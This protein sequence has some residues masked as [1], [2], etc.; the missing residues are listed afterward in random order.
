MTCWD[1]LQIEPTL[2]QKLIKC[3][4]AK[5]LQAYH[6]EEDP[7]GFQKLRVAFEEALEKS[8]YLDSQSCPNKVMPH[9][10][11]TSAKKKSGG[12]EQQEHASWRLLENNAD[13]ASEGS[14]WVDEP[15]VLAQQRMARIADLYADFSRRV[16]RVQWQEIFADLR[17]WPVD[18]RLLLSFSLFAFLGQNPWVPPFVW[19]L[20]QELFDWRAVQIDLNKRF[21]ETMVDAVFWRIDNCRWM[22]GY[23]SVPIIPLVDYDTY[24]YHREHA[25][26]A[27]I[28]ADLE[29]AE[30][31]L[32]RA[33]SLLPGDCQLQ[34]LAIHSRLMAG[35]N[36]SALARSE[37]LTRDH[38]DDL[39][40]RLQH[41][42]LLLANGRASAALG[43]FQAMLGNAP[44][45]TA[46]LIGL[47]RSHMALGNLFEAQRL[48]EAALD[49]CPDHV[50]A[51]MELLRVCHRLTSRSLA[52]LGNQ[53][54]SAN[55]LLRIAEAYFGSGMYPQAEKIIADHIHQVVESDVY[56][57]WARI[58]DRLE[59]PQK[60]VALFDQ[61]RQIAEQNGENQYNILI[62]R[63]IFHYNRDAFQLAIADLERAR[64]MSLPVIDT[65]VWYY[66]ADAYYQT[67][68]FDQSIQHF[69]VL[70]D[71]DDSEPSCYLYR[72]CAHFGKQD[73]ASA[74]KDFQEALQ[75]E[76]YCSARLWIGKCHVEMKQYDQALAAFDDAEAFEPDSGELFHYRAR[77]AFERGDARGARPH[78]DRS[79]ALDPENL[80][81]QRLAG[82]I[83]DALGDESRA[84]ACFKMYLKQPQAGPM[85]GV[86]AAHYCLARNKIG[87][88][89]KYLEPMLETE[90]KSWTL[91][92][93]ADVLSKQGKWKRALGYTEKYFETVERSA[94]EIDEIA[95]FL[96][97]KL[98][99]IFYWNRPRE[100]L[101]DLHQACELEAC[102]MA[103]YYLSLAYFDLRDLPNCETFARAAL[104]RDPSNPDFGKLVEGIERFK[105]FGWLRQKLIS[106]KAIKLWEQT[107][108]EPWYCVGD[109]GDLGF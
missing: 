9:G 81:S 21:P 7:V 60:A 79:L 42:C 106:E 97:G 49:R 15:E 18:A 50:E 100:S 8:K 68:A 30:S 88:A 89:V 36:P 5:L 83:Y 64:E 37:T 69:N 25:A 67:N 20:A 39:D 90:E 53:S 70:I 80:S 2:N 59:Q 93:L 56:L 41:A 102:D 109:F 58:W 105:R 38:P 98:K 62:H 27:I 3:A 11:E 44:D 72:G 32:A 26:H 104:S 63:G 84:M 19:A 65:R 47:A 101:P 29:K 77:C 76:Y 103:F 99:Y 40:G 35:D 95:F 14:R 71:A 52:E 1:I 54:P 34:R 94:E 13:A 45:N 33:S 24:L 87:E 86:W 57:L 43:A 31:H 6:P 61:A 91:L 85:N 78:I 10:R 23:D 107:Q 28:R 55:L 92:A 4:Y 73:F 96:R 12:N 48:L 16:D 17:R 66:L 82:Y 75:R 22:P 108:A 51:H 74:L 46:G